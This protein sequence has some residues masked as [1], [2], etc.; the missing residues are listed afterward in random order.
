MPVKWPALRSLAQSRTGFQLDDAA[1]ALALTSS[2]VNSFSQQAL[3][4]LPGIVGSAALEIAKAGNSLVQQAQGRK[5]PQAEDAGIRSQA[6]EA[7]VSS[8]VSTAEAANDVFSALGLQVRILHPSLP[9]S[10]T[11]VKI[12]RG[13]VP[14]AGNTDTEQSRMT[15]RQF[16]QFMRQARQEGR[17]SEGGDQIERYIQDMSNAG[18]LQMIPLLS[19]SF[20]HKLY[21]DIARLLVF[22]FQRCLMTLNDASVW[23]HTLQVTSKG[24][25]TRH[26]P[27]L[28]TS[29][30]GSA[31]LE[32]VVDM[33]LLSQRFHLPWL[34]RSTQRRLYINCIMV[35]FQLVEDLL[36]G[37]G[38]EIHFMGHKVKFELEAQPLQL[39]KQMLQENPVKHCQIDEA[40]LA[41]LVDE[42]LADEETNLVWMPDCIESQL[43]QNVMRLLIRM[44]EHVVS[45]LKLSILGRKIE[46]S[47]LS[48]MD[49][50]AHEEFV[51]DKRAEAT[52]YY[53]EEDPFLTVSATE[54]EERLKDLDEQRR[55]LKALQELG[56]ADFDLTAEVP[57]M[58]Q[59][60]ASVH[61]S[62]PDGQKADVLARDGS[63]C[64]PLE[65]SQEVH[66]F[67][68]LAYTLKLGRHLSVKFDVD[69]N[70]EVPHSMIADLDS[71]ALWMPWCT[72]G[73]VQQRIAPP[74]T[75]PNEAQFKE[76]CYG[77]V[78]FGFETGSF[79]GTLGDTVGYEV[80]ICHPQLSDGRKT[81]RV[82]ADAKQ[83]FAYGKRLAYDWRFWEVGPSK[84][85]VELDMLFQAQSVLYMP[86][87][88]SMQHMVINNMLSAFKAHA[89]K[90]YAERRDKSTVPE[91]LEKRFRLTRP[92]T[93]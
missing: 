77:N 12:S 27:T 33:M 84:T 19:Y 83:G 47:I 2:T 69:A 91:Q 66:E 68:R 87:W 9:N 1:R 50:R 57:M 81:A 10:Q 86:V 82:C 60:G 20:Q 80:T 35:V 73:S 3:G 62:Q 72:A 76:V 30:V 13:R 4:K 71:Y 21:V 85:K 52:V 78:T 59:D 54:L 7:V 14:D 56:S 88:D 22:A 36:A 17:A 15:P 39:V 67:Q 32:A 26:L 63:R 70:I 24:Y 79:L 37:D 38:E 8:A 18:R 42:L 40:V 28:Q 6:R 45:G 75:G 90:I 92:C 51:R 58:M 41:E 11:R 74:A 93:I 89:E 46:M 29:K 55:V 65:E 43:Y 5:I 53:E 23:G 16:V 61:D 49:L 44:A 64:T 34:P 31:Q 48:T 25:L